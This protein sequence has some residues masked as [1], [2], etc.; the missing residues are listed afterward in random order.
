MDV[1]HY[2]PEHLT[3]TA[4]GSAAL[5]CPEGSPQLIRKV[6][7]EKLPT[8]GSSFPLDLSAT[9]IPTPSKINRPNQAK[10]LESVFFWTKPEF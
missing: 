10:P 6:A 9:L 2:L 7:E 8:T 5:G 3:N 1:P 4:L